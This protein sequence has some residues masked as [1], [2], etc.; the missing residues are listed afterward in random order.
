MSVQIQSI[1]A[2]Q[3]YDSR[4]KPTVQVIL[5]TKLGSYSA[6]VPSGASKGEHEAVELRDGGDAFLGQGVLRAVRN[7]NTIIAPAL[8]GRACDEQA[9]IDQ[10]MIDLDGTDSKSK[11]GANAILAVSMACARAGAAAQHVPLY[12]YLEHLLDLP[13]KPLLLPTPCFNV[14]NGGVHSGNELGPQEFMIVPVGASSFAEAMEMGTTV[15]QTLKS[16]LKERFGLSGT[17]VGDE[18]GFAPPI[19]TAVQALDLLTEAVHRCHYEGRVKFAMDPASTEFFNAERGEYN[20]AFKQDGKS[21]SAAGDNVHSRAS[22]AAFYAQLVAKYPIILLED[23]FAQDDWQSFIDF[24]RSMSASGSSLEIVGDDLLATNPQRIQRAIDAKA[25]NSMLLKINQIGSISEAIGAARLAYSAGWK[26]F[27][28]HRSGETTDDF[29]AD[30]TVGI[31]SG[32]LKSGAPCRGERLAK[33]NRLLDIEDEL[34][35]DSSK[36][37]FAGARMS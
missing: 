35:Q 13:S 36:T 34:N 11:L 3:R 7:V 28:S 25:C 15:Y 6:L 20:L 24:T 17:N 4:G 21:A 27:V 30:L 18:G 8:L 23:P 10:I 9:A 1:V 14:I 37:P 19:A 26:V 2:S 12:R 16:V 31:G 29:I 32:H 33:Y 22:M 5:R